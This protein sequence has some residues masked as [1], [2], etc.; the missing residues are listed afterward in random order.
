MRWLHSDGVLNVGARGQIFGRMSAD[1]GATIGTGCEFERMS[2][3]VIRF[4]TG[5]ARV[6][7]AES[8]LEREQWTPTDD[9]EVID[10]ETW[11]TPTDLWIEDRSRVDKNMII[12]RGLFFIRSCWV[13]LSLARALAPGISS[14]DYVI[15]RLKVEAMGVVTIF[16]AGYIAAIIAHRSQPS[17]YSRFPSG[18][19]FSSTPTSS[20]NS[21]IGAKHWCP[22]QT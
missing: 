3:P 9:I 13:E 1:G 15:A 2:S 14:V 5:G 17:T 18:R 16:V 4:S 11:K 12:K 21:C 22:W 19:V 10:E 20:A 6:P 8:G 7:R